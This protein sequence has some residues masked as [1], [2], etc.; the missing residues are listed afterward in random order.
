MNSDFE[1]IDVEPTD[2]EQK[3]ALMTPRILP[4]QQTIRQY[5]LKSFGML[6]IGFLL[7][8]FATYVAA[9][10]PVTPE[11][12]VQYFDSFR[13][14]QAVFVFDENLLSDFRRP[15][16]SCRLKVHLVPAEKPLEQDYRYFN[17]LHKELNQ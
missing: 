4:Q 12:S 17:L 1:Q 2:F 10:F 8:V 5:P 7:G 6:A 3:L 16:D 14:P 13:H 15:I 11:N 9:F